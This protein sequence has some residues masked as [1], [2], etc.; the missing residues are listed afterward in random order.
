MSYR[1][2][3]TRVITTLAQLLTAPRTDAQCDAD[4]QPSDPV[5]AGCATIRTAVDEIGRDS[6][7]MLRLLDTAITHGHTVQWQQERR[8]LVARL[9]RS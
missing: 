7:D 1:A 4:V 3:Y 5:R 2:P 6:A 9:K 8:D